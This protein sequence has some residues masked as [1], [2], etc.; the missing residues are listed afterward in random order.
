MTE[1]VAKST[2]SVPMGWFDEDGV[3][4]CVCDQSD[5]NAISFQQVIWFA[6]AVHRMTTSLRHTLH[7]QKKERERQT[8]GG[9]AVVTQKEPSI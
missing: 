4:V 1:S 5:K 8:V 6:V 2:C 3:C 9:F 7:L